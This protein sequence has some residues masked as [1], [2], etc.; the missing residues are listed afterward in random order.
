MRAVA[1][2]RYR[3]GPGSG[4]G[5]R[6]DPLHAKLAESLGRLACGGRAGA[7]RTLARFDSYCKRF[8]QEA[9]T[10]PPPTVRYELLDRSDSSAMARSCPGRALEHCDANNVVRVVSGSL[11]LPCAG[12]L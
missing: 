1:R 11:Q 5:G 12:V 2:V 6:R 3:V 4:D 9:G 10:P 7:Q 8:V